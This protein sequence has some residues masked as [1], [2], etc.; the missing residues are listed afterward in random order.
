[1][2]ASWLLHLLLNS[3][4]LMVIAGYFPG[5]HLSGVGAAI[6]ASV[7]ISIFNVIVRP[8]IILLTLPVTVL[9]LGLFLFVIN[10]I[11]LMLAASLMGSAFV[12]TSFWMALLAAILISILHVLLQNFVVKP[13]RKR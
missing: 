12:I 8:L 5:F 11:I 13:L 3:I 9:S 7:L 1:M 4:I 6:G 10:A 2:I